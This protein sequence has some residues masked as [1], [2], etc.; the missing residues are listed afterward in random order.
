MIVLPLQPRLSVDDENRH[1]ASLLLPHS[2]L[3]FIYLLSF[4][5]LHRVYAS[6]RSDLPSRRMPLGL[7]EDCMFIPICVG[8]ILFAFLSSFHDWILLL[9]L[10]RVTLHA[11]LTSLEMFSA[12]IIQ[13]HLVMVGVGYDLYFPLVPE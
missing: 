7:L 8:F 5:L 6:I 2:V 11:S 13:H 12:S 4:S 10:F 3:F 9:S 1:L